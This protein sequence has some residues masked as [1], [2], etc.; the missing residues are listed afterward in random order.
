MQIARRFSLTENRA[1]LQFGARPAAG[2][3]F[4]P[5][6]TFFIQSIS[7][8]EERTAFNC[9]LECP[10]AK[11]HKN[12][13]LLITAPEEA[14]TQ[15]LGVLKFLQTAFLTLGYTTQ[16]APIP[17]EAQAD[18]EAIAT[19]AAAMANATSQPGTAEAT[20]QTAEALMKNAGS[21][22]AA[23]NDE[24]LT[25][26]ATAVTGGK[27]YIYE[28]EAAKGNAVRM[29]THD[30]QY[31]P[32]G[33]LPAELRIIDGQKEFPVQPAPTNVST[34]VPA[35]AEAA[36][37]SATETTTP[38]ATVTAEASVA[39]APETSGITPATAEVSPTSTETTPPPAS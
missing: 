35:M 6:A 12:F 34:E 37:A 9:A 27:K 21:A 2:E 25:E 19:A 36:A 20:L 7:Q 14:E 11:L 29:R 30:G 4:T 24:S 33:Q 10:S 31:V 15:L 38:T 39:P 16:R 28:K 23:T 5:H 17:A 26:E 22:T 1:S 18:A 32:E 8:K 3:D 13:R